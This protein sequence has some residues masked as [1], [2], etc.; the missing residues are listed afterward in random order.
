VDPALLQARPFTPLR[1][2]VNDPSS[3]GNA[4][5]IPSTQELRF[6]VVEDRPTARSAGVVFHEFGHAVTDTMSRLSQ[7]K[8]INAPS[9]GLS[10]GYSDYFAAA[11]LG[12]P[13]VGDYV[14]NNINGAR[15]CADPNA[16]FPAGFAGPEHVNGMAWAAVLWALRGRLGGDAADRLVVES[17]E[18]VDDTSTFEDARAALRTADAQLTGGENRAA[19]DEEFDART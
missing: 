14:A 2:L 6:G 1:V 16:R 15:N 7:A 11:F 17:L 9:R 19:I 4:Y 13:R 10:E 8:I 3:S 18:F 12:D 5:W